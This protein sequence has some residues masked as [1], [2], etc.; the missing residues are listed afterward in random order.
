MWER[1]R[2]VTEVDVVTG[3]PGFQSSQTVENDLPFALFV[4]GVRP[5]LVANLD[6]EGGMAGKSGLSV[7][8]DPSA[9]ST[10]LR[11]PQVASSHSSAH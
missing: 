8:T 3:G 2:F 5:L 6:G 10:F 11:T 9:M 4:S 1:I 7:K